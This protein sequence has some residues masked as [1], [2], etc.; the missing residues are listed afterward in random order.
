MEFEEQKLNN[1]IKRAGV[2]QFLENANYCGQVVGGLQ[3]LLEEYILTPSCCVHFFV[4]KKQQLRAWSP[5][6]DL[7]L[8]PLLEISIMG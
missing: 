5:K 4:R 6:E 1:S 2:L 3:L 7:S 8:I